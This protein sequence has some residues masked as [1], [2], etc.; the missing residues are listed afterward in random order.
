MFNQLEKIIPGFELSTSKSSKIL[1]EWSNMCS[2][3]WL[4]YSLLEFFLRSESCKIIFVGS[5][6]SYLHH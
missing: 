6:E 4:N 2:G 5:Q 1:V 3:E